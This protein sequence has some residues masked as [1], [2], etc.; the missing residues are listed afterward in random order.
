MIGEPVVPAGEATTGAGAS[1]AAPESATTETTPTSTT[2]EAK[3]NKRNSIFGNIFGKKDASTGSADTPPAV[4]AKDEQSAVS[5]TAPQLDNPVTSSTAEPTAA[6]TEIP[7]TS[8]EAAAPAAAAS[9]LASTDKR[10]SSFFGNLGT[11]KERRAGATSDNELTDGEGKK[12]SPGGFGGLLRKASR[13]QKGSSS[14]S[15]DAANVPLPTEASA[16]ATST[17]ENLA[18][19]T[20]TTEGVTGTHEQT[21]VSA[22]A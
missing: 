22:T 14:T 1:G 5:S 16:E 21:P 6:T 7:T 12:Q 19:K 4:P 15:K 11:K 9:P 18:G 17:G 8:T 3:P 10:R 2:R 20:A 13:A